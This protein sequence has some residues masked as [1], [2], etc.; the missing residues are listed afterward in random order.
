M[1]MGMKIK[2][3]EV[4]GGGGLGWKQEVKKDKVERGRGRG[5]GNAALLD[6]DRRRGLTEAEQRKQPGGEPC[7][8]PC[9][10]FPPV[11]QG[12]SLK[13]HFQLESKCS[14][15]KQD[16]DNHKSRGEEVL[17]EGASV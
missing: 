9:L 1:M 12:T 5:E 15:D 13:V 4:G 14:A 6:E 11:P 17:G 7:S 10:D 2:C 3:K 16:K 8:W